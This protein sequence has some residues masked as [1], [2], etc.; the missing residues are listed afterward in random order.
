MKEDKLVVVGGLLIFNGGNLYWAW[1]D[2]VRRRL[3]LI[4]IFFGSLP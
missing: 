1:A 2:V 3:S 4:N